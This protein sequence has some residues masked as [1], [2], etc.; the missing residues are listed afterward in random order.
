MLFVVG[1]AACRAVRVIGGRERK[2]GAMYGGDTTTVRL[3]ETL[4]SS[5]KEKEMWMGRRLHHQ[6]NAN[7]TENSVSQRGRAWW[8]RGHTGKNEEK[9][10]EKKGK[11]ELSGYRLS[12]AALHVS[13]TGV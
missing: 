8:E 9:V 2:A 7:N 1:H 11:R 5:K 6:V 10:K 12:V 3:A 13:D 4:K